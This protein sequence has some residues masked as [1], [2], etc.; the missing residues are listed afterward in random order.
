MVNRVTP[1]EAHEKWEKGEAVLLD[2]RRG[3]WN[4]SEVKAEGAVR[5]PP[6][7][8]ELH[9]TELPKDKEIIAYCT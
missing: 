2:V 8:I 7:E 4:E 3:S 5:I 9:Y 1:E 6:D